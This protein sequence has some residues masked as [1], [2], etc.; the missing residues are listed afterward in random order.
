[1]CLPITKDE[2]RFHVLFLC[3]LVHLVCMLE[4]SHASSLV[5]CGFRKLWPVISGNFGW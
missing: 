5:D 4:V 1:M 2:R 3:A